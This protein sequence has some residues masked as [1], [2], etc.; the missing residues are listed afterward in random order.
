MSPGEA[1]YLAGF[2]TC[3]ILYSAQCSAEGQL[4]AFTTARYGRKQT[5]KQ[6][7]G[8]VMRALLKN[9]NSLQ[10]LDQ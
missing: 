1:F 10:L 6:D 4:P 2:I 7:G 8:Q 9:A 5:G 3:H